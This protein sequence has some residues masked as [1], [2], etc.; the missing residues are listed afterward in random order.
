[1]NNLKEKF[2]RLNVCVLVPTYNNCGT[3][4]TVLNNILEYT[5]DL[6]VVND[7]STDQTAEVLSSFTTV[8]IVTIP[9]NKGK[10]NALRVGFKH[11]FKK[12][13]YYVITIDSDGQHFPSD[14][15]AFLDKIEAEPDSLII[16]ARNM[17]MEGIPSKSS[18]GNKFSNFWYKIDTGISLPDTQT[19]YRLY[20][21]KRLANLYYFTPKFEF[22]IEVLVRAAWMG[23][24]VTYIPVK[25]YYAPSTERISHF[26]PFRDFTRISI[27]NTFLFLLAFLF[28][29]PRLWLIKQKKKG[30]KEIIGANDSNFKIASAIGFGIFMGIFPVWG[31]QMII[32]GFIAHFVRLNK[33]IVL[34]ASNISI[35]PFI[36]VILYLSF[37]VGE[38]ILPGDS[39]NVSVLTNELIV[40]FDNGFH[41]SDFF[42]ILGESLKL[43]L[44]GAIV[45]SIIAALFTWVIALVSLR[46]FRNQK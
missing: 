35:P 42:R 44:I 1:M 29:R 41:W 45:L 14:L 8:D 28:F 24:N 12:G 17:S 40:L 22:E 25:V 36:P 10:G 18:F 4:G 39:Q 21:I 13:Y 34:L 46:I 6:I 30:I 7:G 26:R 5:D 32:A 43:Y 33:V 37:K 15:P 38:L 3:L 2:K 9:Q 31:F 16:G 27:L 23:I 20:P 19:G 11:A